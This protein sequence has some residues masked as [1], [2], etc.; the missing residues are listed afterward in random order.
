MRNFVSGL[1]SSVG[2]AVLLVACLTIASSLDLTGWRRSA[3]YL[4]AAL[5]AVAASFPLNWYGVN[6]LT[7]LLFGGGGDAL[8]SSDRISVGLLWR[9]VPKMLLGFILVG[10]AFMHFRDAQQRAAA[11]N[12]AQLEQAKIAR[13]TY[14]SRLRAAQARV[15]PQFLFETLRR[16]QV[17]Y[18]ADSVRAERMLDDLILFLRR[19]LPAIDSPT[20]SVTAEV[21][22]A[23]AWL[24]IVEARRGDR[25]RSSVRVTAD[26]DRLRLPPMVLL[27]MVQR[28]AGTDAGPRT[29]VNIEIDAVGDRLRI[30]VAAFPANSIFSDTEAVEAD[31]ASLYGSNACVHAHDLDHGLRLAID[32][33]GEAT[34]T[35]EA[36]G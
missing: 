30:A 12:N 27:P 32:L 11:L 29:H 19:A 16:V 5:I 17:L 14:E 10:L 13:D 20:S 9:T 31:L 15:E 36:T 25:L 18:S 6:D 28:A 1:L 22:L 24:R 33:P 34:A 21:A 4:S 7:W 23:R 35:G 2:E 26:A 8:R 3:A